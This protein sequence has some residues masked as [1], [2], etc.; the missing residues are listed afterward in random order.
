M[1]GKIKAYRKNFMKQQH[2]QESKYKKVE[3]DK[4]DLSYPHFERFVI[5]CDKT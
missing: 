1:K 5:K 4:W 2:Y 3:E